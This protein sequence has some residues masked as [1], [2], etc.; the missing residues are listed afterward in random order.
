LLPRWIRAAARLR[1][2][3][4]APL[5]FFALSAAVTLKA[6]L[7]FMERG[8]CLPPRIAHGFVRL[9]A[10]AALMLV[11]FLLVKRGLLGRR[12]AWVR[13][14]APFLFCLLVY[15]NLHDT[16]YFVNSHDVHDAL[17]AIDAWVFGVQ[18][19]VWAQRFYHP[20]LSDVFSLA[21]MNYFVIS[22]VV[23]G[24]LLLE[25]RRAEMREA[26]LGTVLCFYMGYV[27]YVLFPAA[28]PRL[29]LASQFVR[30]FSGSWLTAV[31]LRMVEISPTSSR[32]AFPSLHCAVTLITVM[33]AYRFRRLLFWIV[34]GPAIL[35]VLATVYLRHHYVVD[36]AAGFLLAVVVHA[37]TP[38]VAEAWARLQAR[39]AEEDAAPDLA[40]AEG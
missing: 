4:F 10:T 31:Q 9:A 34:L 2:E 32:G 13:D 3:E 33:Y 22:V 30:D 25:G 28:P 11:F 7:F 39:A 12:L 8:E 14:V 6:S 38:R 27:L 1:L 21:Y 35:L 23:V 36:I 40:E 24:W 37:I 26:L 18:P 29:T 16:I 19:T 20:V 5:A 15:T 17:I